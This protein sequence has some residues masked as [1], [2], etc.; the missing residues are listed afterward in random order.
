MGKK[1]SAPATSA[2]ELYRDAR[3]RWSAAIDLDL[4]DEEES[5]LRVAGILRKAMGQDPQHVRATAL[6][7][8]LLAA[9]PA[10]DEAAP[11][12]E[13]LI[14]LEPDNEEHRLR[15]RL[16]ALPDGTE[17]RGKV[18]ERLAVKWMGTSDW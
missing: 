16:L 15:Q 3:K 4:Y 10:Y 1:K 18:M 11:L 7:C 8:D 14:E 17:K 6:L 9:L 5:I 12:A 13:R 2:E